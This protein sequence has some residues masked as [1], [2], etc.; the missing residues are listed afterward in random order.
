M[1]RF[2]TT[3]LLWSEGQRILLML[4]VAS[5][6]A[7]I[8]YVPLL[9]IIAGLFLFCLYFFRNPTR[10]CVEALHDEN[11]VICPADGIVVSVDC[12]DTNMAGYSKKVSIFLSLFDVHVNWIPIAGTVEGV[13]YKQGTFSLAF[14]PK[15]S[16]FNEH[17]DILINNGNGT[18]IIVRQIAGSLARRISCWV[19]PKNVVKAGQKYGMIKF[20]SRVDIFLPS[21]TEVQVA[22]GQR[23]FGGQTVIGRL[24]CQ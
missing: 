19:S 5:L 8:I 3:N 23:V 7:I 14:L 16:L 11:I 21:T 2:I 9:Y 1:F 24:L 18:T 4:G 6:G 15:S 12:N 17:N 22:K 10:F 13:M 20:G